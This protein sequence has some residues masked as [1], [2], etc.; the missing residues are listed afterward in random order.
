MG[1][2][3]TK[4]EQS[5]PK[6]NYSNVTLLPTMVIPNLL[7]EEYRAATDGCKKPYKHIQAIPEGS[8]CCL[9]RT[10]HKRYKS[11]TMRDGAWL[12]SSPWQTR[13]QCWTGHS[14]GDSGAAPPQRVGSKDTTWAPGLG[15][16]EGPGQAQESPGQARQSHVQPERN[17]RCLL[18]LQNPNEQVTPVEKATATIPR[19][20]ITQSC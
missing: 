3:F 16:A 15:G 11:I 10:L 13:L 4:V 14:D 1:L 19:A 12:W 9:P 2:K 6:P 5:W 8:S 18:L 17:C 7:F 20:K